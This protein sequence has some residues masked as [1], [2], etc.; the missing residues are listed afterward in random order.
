MAQRAETLN[1]L[2]RSRSDLVSVVPFRSSPN[3]A[4]LQMQRRQRAIV[5]RCTTAWSLLVRSSSS[6]T[7]IATK[8]VITVRN[9]WE[10]TREQNPLHI[11][12]AS[13]G[14]GLALGVAIRV[15]RSHR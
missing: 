6:V 13:A 8:M 2:Q 3:A 11:V 4:Q 5:E 12:A 7:N 1:P 9:R 15:W 14:I 10:A